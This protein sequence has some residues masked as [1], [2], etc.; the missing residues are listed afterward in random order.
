MPTQIRPKGIGKDIA[1]SILGI[2]QNMLYKKTKKE[3]ERDDQIFLRQ[4]TTSSRIF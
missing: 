1:F 4:S 3:K 2:P